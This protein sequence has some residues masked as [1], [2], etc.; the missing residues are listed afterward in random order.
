M[1][2]LTEIVQV[3]R[4]LRQIARPGEAPDE[5]LHEIMGVELPGGASR[6]KARFQHLAHDGRFRDPTGPGSGGQPRVQLRGHLAGDR[7]HGGQGITLACTSQYQATTQL[8]A[9][10]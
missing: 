2:S 10:E 7:W 6:G 3:T 9:V 5:M 4:R 1:I 8:T